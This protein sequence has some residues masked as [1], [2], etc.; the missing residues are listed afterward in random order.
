MFHC[1]DISLIALSDSFVIPWNDC[2]YCASTTRKSVA[3]FTA[4]TP[5]APLA[6]ARALPVEEIIPD[7]VLENEELILPETATALFAALS[8]PFVRLLA[9]FEPMPMVLLVILFN[10]L[11]IKLA[12]SCDTLTA[13][14]IPFRM[15]SGIFAPMLE[16]TR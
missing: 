4:N 13:L 10:A 12:P 1:F 3:D 5:K 7:A 16:I 11:A 2:A 14:F 9:T 8:S 15:G 6:I